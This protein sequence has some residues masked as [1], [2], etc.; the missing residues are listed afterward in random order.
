MYGLMKFNHTSSEFS[1]RYFFKL[2][3]EAEPS[4]QRIT[5]RAVIPFSILVFHSELSNNQSLSHT[6][7]QEWNFTD[8]VKRAIA[9]VKENEPEHEMAIRAIVWEKI[10][11][12]V[13]ANIDGIKTVRAIKGVIAEVMIIR[14]AR[15]GCVK[16]QRKRENDILRQF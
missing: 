3:S 8:L 16:M 15:G 2:Q 4:I 14:E 11:W 1:P 13:E 12:R 5:K 7:A 6:F 10:D 9:T